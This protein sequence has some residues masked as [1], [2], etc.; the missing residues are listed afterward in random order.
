M[1]I[2]LSGPL[3]RKG[4]IHVMV[5]GTRSD[6]KPLLLGGGGLCCFHELSLGMHSY[7]G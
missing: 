2:D 7:V 5:L 6:T 3:L 4:S 1:L